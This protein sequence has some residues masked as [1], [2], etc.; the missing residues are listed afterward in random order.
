MAM[1]EI[2]EG[3][4]NEVNAIFEK[5]GYDKLETDKDVGNWVYAI[6]EDWMAEE[7]GV[8]WQEEALRYMGEEAQ[9]I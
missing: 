7:F 3:T 5:Y 8:E 6:I 9:D 4:L 2:D 1:I